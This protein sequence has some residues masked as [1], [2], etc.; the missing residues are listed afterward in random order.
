M[1]ISLGID[2]PEGAIFLRYFLASLVLVGAVFGAL[3]FPG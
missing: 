2:T 1:E 3:N